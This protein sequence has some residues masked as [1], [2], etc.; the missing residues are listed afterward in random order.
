MPALDLGDVCEK[1]T[2]RRHH[3]FYGSS[4]AI[5]VDQPQLMT[6]ASL[7]DWHE[8][9]V[10]YMLLPGPEINISTWVQSDACC[11]LGQGS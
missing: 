5:S 1:V 9:D 10:I 6:A 8:E 2:Q 11:V 7:T 4:R 3:Y